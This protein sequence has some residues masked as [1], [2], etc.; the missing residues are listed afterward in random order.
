MQLKLKAT[1]ILGFGIIGYIYAI[2]HFILF[3]LPGGV[4]KII[5]KK[6]RK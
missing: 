3:M 1:K 5:Y 6:L 4:K 2:A